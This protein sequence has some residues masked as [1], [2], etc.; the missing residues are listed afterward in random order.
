[1]SE[2][3]AEKK[4]RARRWN[5]ALWLLVTA[6]I[7]LLPS[8]IH[9][10]SFTATLDRD[11]VPVGETV[12]LS[13]R[14]S[15][16]EPS[17]LPNIPALPGLHATYAGRSSEMSIHNGQVSS[18]VT[19][20]YHLT[21]RQTGV[22]TIPAME[23]MVGRERV[24]AGP[25]RLTVL[26][27]GASAPVGAGESSPVLLLR[28]HVPKKEVYVGE[29][30]LSELQLLLRPDVQQ[31]EGFRL[32]DFP[33]EGF[34]A[35]KMVEGQ[36]R[37]VQIGSQQ[38]T[39]IPLHIP[40]K[41]LRAGTYAL[42]PARVQV[43]VVLPRV[44]RT[45][46]FFDFGT[47]SG[48][49][50]R[51]TLATEPVE[52]KSL[53]LPDDNVPPGFT[54]AVGVFSLETHVSPTNIAVGDPIT[55]RV[56]IAGRGDFDS[57]TV[58][59]QPTWSDFKT[60][61]PTSRVEV[62]QPGIQGKKTFEQVVVPEKADLSVL[63]GLV[64]SYFDPERRAYQQ[65]SSPN[66]PLVVRPVGAQSMPTI[67]APL[68]DSDLKQAPVRDIVHIK[69]RLGTVAT[70]ESPLLARPWF[71]LL[72]MVPL[73]VLGASIA[74]RKRKEALANNPRLR[75]RKQA[76]Q[77]V[78]NGLEQL[79]AQAAA[80]DSEGFFET[81][82]RLLQEVIGERLDLPASAI[83]E[84]VV[85]EHLKPR[86]YPDELRSGVSELFEACNLAR[87]A[88]VRSSEQLTAFIPKVEAVLDRLRNFQA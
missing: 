25:L 80:N 50:R 67:A 84:A 26:E 16:G 44:R 52:M 40:L 27:A 39:L 54:G 69:P 78:K 4:R 42:G 10:A 36:R 47:M 22:I 74:W 13:L 65:L 20:S 53:P 31:V 72:Q 34:S 75:R 88:P 37:A 45:R 61:P 48:E 58:P 77:V 30:I 55:V 18:S 17:A 7:A 81:V 33:M 56:E 71:L 21:P 1:M 24:T 23:A 60:Y 70:A 59:E 73:L 19:H 57:L 41:A 8:V 29:L 2:Y 66:T 83:T 79:R 85:E 68:A 28:L 3:R 32:D 35:G 15:G 63:P 64:F 49:R 51:A 38:Y 12:V 11:T 6:A 43:E 9:A 46:S 5:W 86:G 87:Y 82:M 62:E 76:A 14:F